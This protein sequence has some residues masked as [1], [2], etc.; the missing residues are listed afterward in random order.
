[1]SIDRGMDKENV[2]PLYNGVLLSHE[3]HEIM[4][5]AATLMDPEMV[6]LSELSQTERR[7][8]CEITY[9]WN[10]KYNSMNLFAK[11]KPTHRRKKTTRLPKG[12]LRGENILGVWTDNYYI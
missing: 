12:K 6:T 7:V 5:F 10:L 9:T 3:K 4:P 2:V 8:S 11:Q 1:M